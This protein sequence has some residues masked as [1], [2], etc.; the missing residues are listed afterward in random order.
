MTEAQ[1]ILE[2]IENV[3]PSD[4]DTMDEIDA[5][6]ECFVNPNNTNPHKVET[7]SFWYII[8][9]ADQRVTP[10]FEYTRSR[11][12][13]KAIRPEGAYVFQSP[14][15]DKKWAC[16]S[17]YWSREEDMDFMDFSSPKL[18]TEELAELHAIIQAI[19]FERTLQ[20]K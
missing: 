3:E 4:T 6:V 7:S 10:P 12:A 14:Y 8:N 9:W 17:N 19:E 15:S 18:P 16:F 20:N 5:R 1:K 2:L 11:D 13:L